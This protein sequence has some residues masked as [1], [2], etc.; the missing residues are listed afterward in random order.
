[1]GHFA[2][3]TRERVV[4]NRL[5]NVAVGAQRVGTRDVFLFVGGGEDNDWHRPRPCFAPHRLKHFQPTDLGQ[6]QVEQDEVRHVAHVAMCE[7]A[8]GVEKIP[9]VCAVFQDNNFMRIGMIA[10][11]AES[12]RCVVAIVLNDE[13]AALRIGHWQVGKLACQLVDAVVTQ[14]ARGRASCRTAFSVTPRE[15]LMVAFQ[16]TPC[17]LLVE[18]NPDDA[19]LTIEALRSKH[20]G[21]TIVHARDGAEARDFLFGIG[22]FS[23]RDSSEVPDLVLLDLRLPKIDGIDVLRRI[24]SD[25]RTQFV[26]VVVLTSSAYEDDLVASYREGANSYIRKAVNYESFVD[27]LEHVCTYWLELNRRPAPPPRGSDG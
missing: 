5:A 23:G 8:N 18:D 15:G 19:A 16:R 22:L 6:L 20:A 14:R 4:V 1:M 13:N 9:C 21:N 2:N 26:P 17:I 3:G 11:C 12:D 25:D 27:E 10:E 24:R 7:C